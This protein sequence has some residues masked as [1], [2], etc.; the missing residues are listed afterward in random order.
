[1]YLIEIQYTKKCYGRYGRMAGDDEL[2][3]G[4]LEKSN[5]VV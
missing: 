2:A 4:N 1:M 3:Q 5:T